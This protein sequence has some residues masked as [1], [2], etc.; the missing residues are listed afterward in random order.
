MV[1]TLTPPLL[2]KACAELSHCIK[3][4]GFEPVL[5]IGIKNGGAEVA[6][7]MRKDFCETDY[8]EVRISRP[9]TQQKEQGLAHKILQMMPLWLCDVLRIAE[10]R[11]REWLSR[12]KR[13]VRIGQ[14]ALPQEAESKLRQS[15]SPKVLIV[16]DA[17]DTGATIR[18]AKEQ[19]QQ[20]YADAEVRVAVIT[21]TTAAPICEADY[22]LYHNRTLCRFPW[23]ND[24]KNI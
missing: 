22:C 1:V 19:L 3:I 20:Q 15:K 7:R 9:D 21:V 5:I 10:S 8:C 6:R 23:S 12:G 16:D 11:I 18:M 14:M 24:Y 4:G 2:D 17:I 13:P